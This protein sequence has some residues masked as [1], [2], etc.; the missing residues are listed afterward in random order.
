VAPAPEGSSGT[1]VLGHRTTTID[2]RP[3]VRAETR[4]TG[5]GLLPRGTRMTGWFVD[6][7]DGTLVATTSEAA[8]AGRYED[9]V[10][11]LDGMVNSLHLSDRKSTC[12]TGRSVPAP[13]RQLELPE[14]ASAIRMAIVEAA[15][16][17]DYDKLAALALAGDSQFT[18]SFGGRGRP[19]AFWR[20][21]EAAG[22]APLRMLVE[23]LDGPS[24]TRDAGGTTQ[25]LWPA[26]YAFER[27]A[28]V[29]ASAREDLR[30]VYGDDDLRR[31]EQFGSY[32]GHRVGITAGGDWIF[33][34][35]G[36]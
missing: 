1:E 4:T 25:Y 7:G 27:W 6:A 8:A 28:D 15:R 17:C 34:V 26:A 33:F 11:V 10:K 30:R 14:A 12:S 31:F 9:N 21:A 22:R 36:D 20:E 19:A 32:V 18:Y 2:G 16:A 24:A 23:L 5:Q 3:A 13:T 35:G 29:P